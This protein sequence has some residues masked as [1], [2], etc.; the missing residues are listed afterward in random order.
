MDATFFDAVPSLDQVEL[1]DRCRAGVAAVG[2]SCVP[3]SDV[4]GTP[5]QAARDPVSPAN[6]VREAKLLTALAAK[7]FELKPTPVGIYIAKHS[8]TIH[9]VPPEEASP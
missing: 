2:P 9:M 3:L 5:P 4:S 1:A 6:Q 7:G 8:S